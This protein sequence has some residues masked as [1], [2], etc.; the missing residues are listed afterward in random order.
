MRRERQKGKKIITLGQLKSLHITK[1]LVV[2]WVDGC[3]GE[4][5]DG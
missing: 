1:W 3:M 2:G 5:M 4:W